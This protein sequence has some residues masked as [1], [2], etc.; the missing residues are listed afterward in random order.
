M[1]EVLD[2][3]LRYAEPRTTTA[4]DVDTT[5]D[6]PLLVSSYTSS[7]APRQVPA[8]ALAGAVVTW[9]AI[10]YGLCYLA[11]PL[12]ASAL[13]L[14]TVF[15]G[16]L[17]LNTLAFVPM[18][19]LTAGLVSAMRPEVVTKASAP[20][21]PVL[22]ATAGSLLVWFGAHELSPLLSS[23]TSMPVGEMLSF[24]TM[25]VVEA[26]M[27]GMMLASFTRS[28]LKAFALG[29]AFQTLLSAFFLGWLL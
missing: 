16:N 20:R 19:L 5:F 29:A 1:A 23:I 9:L 12:F 3:R 21:D 10:V 8:Q 22:A 18:A 2:S 7:S 14:H 15:I 24:V 25:N 13:G 27:I 26:G 6:E 4:F 11:L 17:V 28:P